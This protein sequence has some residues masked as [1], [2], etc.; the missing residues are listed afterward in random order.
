M[1]KAGDLRVMIDH[2]KDRDDV[3]FIDREVDPTHEMSGIM[4]ALEGG[5]AL[6]FNQVKGYPGQQVIA[7]IYAR[8]DRVA[9]LFDSNSEYIAKRL[10]EAIRT[11]L[12]PVEV[13][14]AAC[15]QNLI[16]D[17]IDLMKL[18]PVPRITEQDT[19][20]VI[21]G[22]VAMVKLPDN[23]SFNLS[24]HRLSITGKDWTTIAINPAGHLFHAIKQSNGRCPI[25]INIGFSPAGML[26]AAGGTS[27]TATPLGYSELGFAGSLQGVPVEYVKAKTQDAYSLADAEWVL[28]GYIDMQERADEDV[29]G[30]IKGYLMPEAGGYMGES[31][32]LPTFHV[33]AVTHRDNPYYYFPIGGANETTNLMGLPGEASVYDICKRYNPRLF[34]TCAALPGMRGIGGIVLRVLKDSE[35]D[36]ILVNNLIMTAFAGHTDLSWVVAVDDDVDMLDANDVMWAMLSRMDPKDDMLVTPLSKATSL[37]HRGNKFAAGHKSGY[38]ATYAYGLREG[39][40]FRRPEFPACDMDKWLSEEQQLKIKAQQ[41]DYSKSIARRRK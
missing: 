8:R 36:D 6:V 2:L 29:E 9:E 40:R 13:T 22:A 10:A 5:P 12:D 38:N 3:L 17:D 27:Q 1:T 34:D 23:G 19:A 28:E 30:G 16:V 41:D 31:H 15:Q 21:T 32:K 35:L 37:T 4:K 39:G 33:T 20:H 11:P 18:M 26:A 24:Y 14:T 25:T 7:N